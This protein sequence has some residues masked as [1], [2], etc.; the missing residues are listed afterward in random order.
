MLF[1]NDLKY[2]SD[3]TWLPVVSHGPDQIL[4][5]LL[6]SLFEQSIMLGR[7]WTK[8]SCLGFG[9]HLEDSVML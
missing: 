8:L 9:R 5:V 2:T 1:F 4:K 7:K 3:F 6:L